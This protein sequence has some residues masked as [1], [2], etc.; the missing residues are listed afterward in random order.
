MVVAVEVGTRVSE[1]GGGVRVHGADVI[2]APIVHVPKKKVRNM[3]RI[4]NVI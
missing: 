4:E 1:N 2:D 3:Q